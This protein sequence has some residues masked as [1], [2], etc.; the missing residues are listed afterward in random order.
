MK[1]KKIKI[2]QENMTKAIFMVA[3]YDYE[4][5][6]YRKDDPEACSRR[7]REALTNRGI[8]YA[9]GYNACSSCG[10]TEAFI[11]TA[12]EE[13]TEWEI[14]FR[15]A[16]II[17]SYTEDSADDRVYDIRDNIIVK[18]CSVCKKP[19]HTKTTCKLNEKKYR[20]IGVQTHLVVCPKKKRKISV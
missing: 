9:T 7:L 3:K 15:K 16:R 10:I 1:S 19:G 13:D 12:V 20:S 14:A 8:S 2:V 5:G 11:V 4:D 18:K 6:A 17:A